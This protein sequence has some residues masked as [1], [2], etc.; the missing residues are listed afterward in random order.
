M[1]VVDSVMIFSAALTDEYHYILNPA[2]KAHGNVD[3][4]HR[5]TTL[6][7]WQQLVGY[8]IKPW[9]TQLAPMTALGQSVASCWP[10]QAVLLQQ[11][12]ST[13]IATPINLEN[14]AMSF[15]ADRTSASDGDC[16]T[17][18]ETSSYVASILSMEDVVAR[19][20]WF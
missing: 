16:A 5:W 1:G 10:V 7:Y 15:I 2:E 6:G 8:L 20:Q 18:P 11:Q 14:L 19:T 3:Q 4:L 9:S 12:V 13:I 17:V